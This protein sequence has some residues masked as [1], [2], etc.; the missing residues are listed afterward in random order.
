MTTYYAVSVAICDG[1]ENIRECPIL[2][3]D[4]DCYWHFDET[5]VPTSIDADYK[6][7]LFCQIVQDFWRC[8]ASFS[9][10]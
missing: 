9:T 2:D 8:L 5:S 10:K 6:A 3:F 7:I 1:I 4:V